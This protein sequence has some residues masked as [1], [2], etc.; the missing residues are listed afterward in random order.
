MGRFALSVVGNDDC[1]PRRISLMKEGW[2]NDTLSL[3]QA[4]KEWAEKQKRKKQKR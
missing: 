4:R 3:N 2:A 1:D